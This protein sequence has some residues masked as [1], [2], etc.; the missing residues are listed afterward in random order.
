M[1]REVS[2]FDGA[3]RLKPNKIIIHGAQYRVLTR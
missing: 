2:Y 1:I 3:D